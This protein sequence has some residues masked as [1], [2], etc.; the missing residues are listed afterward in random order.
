L[1]QV[2]VEGLSQFRTVPDGAAAVSFPDSADAV[3]GSQGVGKYSSAAVGAQ[4][5]ESGEMAG[6]HSLI[7]LTAPVTATIAVNFGGFDNG[8]V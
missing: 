8:H 2:I 7:R 5:L 3:S 4:D 6:A 1:S